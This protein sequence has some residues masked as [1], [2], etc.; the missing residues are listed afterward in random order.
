MQFEWDERKALSNLRK[1]GVSF[2]EA[3]TSFADVN[4]IEIEDPDHSASEQRYIHIG[5]TALGRLIVVVHTERGEDVRI[6][7]ARRA[8]WRERVAYEDRQER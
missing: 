4:A 2:G 3:S 5:K 7:S 8:V 6:I 1:H